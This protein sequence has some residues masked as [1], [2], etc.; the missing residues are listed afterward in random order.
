MATY[1]NCLPR[2]RHTLHC[3]ANDES[4]LSAH[5][6]YR[7]LDTVTIIHNICFNNHWQLLLCPSPEGC[8]VLWWVCLSVCLSAQ[9]FRK[10]HGLTLPYL[11]LPYL[12]GGR[13]P[14]APSSAQTT[15]EAKG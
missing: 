6:Q 10:P 4:V 12:R 7:P 5:P 13:H 15:S 9:A 2:Q 8:E 3:S 14:Q 1:T 11:T